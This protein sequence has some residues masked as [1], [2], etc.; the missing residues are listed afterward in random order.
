MAGRDGNS[1]K[2]GVDFEWVKSDTSNAMVRRFFTKAEKKARKE[3]K[4]PKAKG[5]KKASSKKDSPTRPR[6]APPRTSKRP[7]TRPDKN[8]IPRRGD[9]KPIEVTRPEKPTRR[10]RGEEGTAKYRT[11]PSS[12]PRNAPK[13]SSSEKASTRPS[14]KAS[15]PKRVPGRAIVEAIRNVGT[16]KETDAAKLAS[17]TPAERRKYLAERGSEGRKTSRGRNR[18]RTGMAKG[19]MVKANCGASMKPTQKGSK[20]Y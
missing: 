2:E 9:D 7:S 8:K 5:A 6:S 19:G 4:A 17:M 18:T 15:S 14:E 3:G 13:D 12:R 1:P 11:G 10:I 16:G 20:K